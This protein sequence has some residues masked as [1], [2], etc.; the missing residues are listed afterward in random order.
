MTDF[1]TFRAALEAA[2]S[3]AY[4]SPPGLPGTWKVMHIRSGLGRRVLVEYDGILAFARNAKH[5]ACKD[6]R[7]GC[8]HC[9][10]SQCVWE[11]EVE[12]RS[13]PQVSRERVMA[14]TLRLKNF[15]MG[16]RP[17]LGGLDV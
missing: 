12:E 17:L 7:S 13:S 3:N 4:C 15:E 2:D 14:L 10:C 8:V 9:H 1:A 16:K 6:C 5:V 11:A